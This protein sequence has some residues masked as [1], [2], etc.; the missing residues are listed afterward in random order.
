MSTA[1]ADE[2]CLYPAALKVFVFT[3]FMTDHN[4]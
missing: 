4:Q 2:V 1:L 3:A